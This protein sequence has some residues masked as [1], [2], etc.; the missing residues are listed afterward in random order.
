F[1]GL[2]PPQRCWDHRARQPAPRARGPFATREPAVQ[3]RELDPVGLLDRE[4]PPPLLREVAPAE[5][6]LPD[7]LGGRF[8]VH[9][10]TLP[11]APA[12]RRY[13]GEPRART[14]HPRTR[15]GEAGAAP[16]RARGQ[17]P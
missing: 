5:R 9:R 13:D 1:D 8:D 7:R 6:V 2:G 14:R 3:E 12:P 17:A 10:V 4:P 11:G 16:G 15:D